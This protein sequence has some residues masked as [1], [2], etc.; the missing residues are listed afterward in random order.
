[1]L[2]AVAGLLRLLTRTILASTLLLLAGLLAA[3]LLAGP[4]IVLLVLL[5]GVVAGLVGIRHFLF[6]S[7][8][9]AFSY[10]PRVGP[11]R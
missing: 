5:T 6:S 11:Q 8:V 3:A 7:T 2:A 9:D 10:R 1:V 4:R